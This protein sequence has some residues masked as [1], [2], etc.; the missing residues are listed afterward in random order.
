MSIQQSEKRTVSC[1]QFYFTFQMSTSQTK[2]Q[3][4][5]WNTNNL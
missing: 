5:A 3:I 4:M 2:Y 1:E